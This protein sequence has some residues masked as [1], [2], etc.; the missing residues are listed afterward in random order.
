MSEKVIILYDS[1]YKRA[2]EAALDKKIEDVKWYSVDSMTT[3]LYEIAVTIMQ[4]GC[5]TSNARVFVLVGTYKRRKYIWNMLLTIG[6]SEEQLV[7]VYQFYWE[8]QSQ[9]RYRR[10]MS[11]TCDILDGIVLGISHG[12]CGIDVERLPR[13]WVN[14]CCRI[15]IIITKRY[16][17]CWMSMMN[18]LSPSSI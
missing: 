8:M 16:V 14:L 13:R 7:N 5:V 18:K 2:L 11:H 17:R 15:F 12:K 9:M 4:D 3:Q 6:Y 1:Q 10:I